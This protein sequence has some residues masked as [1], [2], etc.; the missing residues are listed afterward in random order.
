MDVVAEIIGKAHRLWCLQSNS[1]VHIADCDQHPLTSRISHGLCGRGHL[2]FKSQLD[3]NLHRNPSSAEPL[4]PSRTSF[5]SES[6]GRSLDTQKTTDL[7]SNSFIL[8]MPQKCRQG[9]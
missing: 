7:R 6:S 9:E 1:D 4:I 5:H 3:A 2:S 8:Q